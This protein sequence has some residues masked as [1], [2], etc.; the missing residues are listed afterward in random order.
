MNPKIS[1][2]LDRIREIEH[3]IEEETKRRRAELQADFEDKRVRF[4]R[5]VLAQHRRFKTGLLNYMITANWLSVLTAPLI[6]SV[7]GPLLLLDVF[8]TVYQRVC[9]P[10]YGIPCVKRSDYFVY[11]RTHLAYLNVIEKVNCAYCSYGNGLMAYAREIV[12]R[13][14]MYWCPIKHARKVLQ[15][16]PYYAGFVDYGDAQSYQRELERLRAQLSQLDRN[17]EENS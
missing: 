8:V 6:Y 11:D 5:E 10:I 1:E 7:L 9:F 3:Q 15:A 17:K 13:T 2:L 14:E 12:A 16:H 4:E